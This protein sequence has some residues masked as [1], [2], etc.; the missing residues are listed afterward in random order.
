[1]KQDD[2]ST[3]LQIPGET[4][5]TIAVDN[6]PL[7]PS[8]QQDIKNA[9]NKYDMDIIFLNQRAIIHSLLVPV[10]VFLTRI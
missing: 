3:N 1:M 2:R 7:K 9:L 10:P 6:A 8:E 5:F 4:G